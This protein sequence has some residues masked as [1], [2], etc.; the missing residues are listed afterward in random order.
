MRHEGYGAWDNNQARKT[1]ETKEGDGPKEANRKENESSRSDTD[2]RAE[3]AKKNVLRS[4]IEGLPVA[5]EDEAVWSSVRDNEWG[6]ALLDATKDKQGTVEVEH[7]ASV[8]AVST[9]AWQALRVENLQ[10]LWKME[11]DPKLADVARSARDTKK[12]AQEALQVLFDRYPDRYENLAEMGI[13]ETKFEVAEIAR[14]LADSDDFRV[15]NLGRALEASMDGKVDP[16]IRLTKLDSFIDRIAETLAEGGQRDVAAAATGRYEESGEQF[17]EDKRGKRRQEAA[18]ILPK[19]KA[20]KQ[21]RDQFSRKNFKKTV[22]SPE[23][24]KAILDARSDIRNQ[25]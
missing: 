3:F 7:E 20:L 2:A 14:E 19:L 16:E 1:P 24:L 23:D 9:V 15:G 5:G 6:K 18:K 12:N 17:D 13:G 4:A 22:I 8:D 10:E 11:A 21:L 25:S